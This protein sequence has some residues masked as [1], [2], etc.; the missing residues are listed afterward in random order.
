MAVLCLVSA[1][2]AVPADDSISVRD[3]QGHQLSSATKAAPITVSQNSISKLEVCWFGRVVTSTVLVTSDAQKPLW[4]SPLSPVS[5]TFTYQ[6]PMSRKAHY[7]VI[8]DTTGRRGLP[9]T[10][11]N[12]ETT[13][14]YTA[15]TSQSASNSYRTRRPK[16]STFQPWLKDQVAAATVK[17]P[18]SMM[19]FAL[20]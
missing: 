3:R 15:L 1:K 18:H 11:A 9:K 8:L 17:G 12:L 13:L 7:L 19:T 14:M 5:T 4:V 20:A 10:Y 16:S 2:P 6:L